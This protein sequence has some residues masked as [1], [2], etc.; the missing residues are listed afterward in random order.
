MTSGGR[1]VSWGVPRPAP[2]ATDPFRADAAGLAIADAL[3]A[4]FRAQAAA[5]EAAGDPTNEATHALKAS[6]YPALTVPA[7]HGGLGVSLHGFARAQERLGAAD[8]SLALIAAMNGHLLGGL[9]EG[10]DEGGWPPDLYAQLARASVERGALSNSLASEPDLGSPSRGGLPRTHAERVP[11]GWQL[12]GRKTWSTGAHALDFYVVTAAVDASSVWRFVVPAGSA[13][14]RVEPTWTGSLALRGSGSHDVVF[15]QV[16]VPNDCAVPPYKAGPCAG[17]WFWTAVAGTYLGV[18]QGA[19]TALVRYANDRVPTALGEPIS[20]LPKVQEAAGQIELELSA[21]RALLHAETRAWAERPEDHERLLPR[22][23]GA[24]S[25]ATNAAVR[26]TDLAL[27]TA[28]G[29]ALTNALPLERFFRDAR[30]GLTHPPA[31]EV[32]MQM[33][34]RQVLGEGSSV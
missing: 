15:D 33:L 19:L 26:A 25:L 29:A 7:E 34:G 10:A 24:K 18:G 13:G 14:V 6:G 8:A 11:G 12:T 2:T 21:A 23:A 1:P 4:V 17:A 3:A 9:G 27:R 32:A 28:G 31:D 5:G 20:T 22:L 30:A 16:L